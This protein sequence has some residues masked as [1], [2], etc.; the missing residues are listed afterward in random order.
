MLGATYHLTAD[1][2]SSPLAWVGPFGL[3]LFSFMVTFSSHWRRWMTLTSIVVLAFA[4]TWFMVQKGFTAITVNGTTAWCLLV[5]TAAGSFLG[6]AL[7]HSLR[8]A[9]RF[10]RYYLVLAAG[11]VIGGLLSSLIIPYVFSRPIE[12]EL[13]SVALLATGIVWL[14]GRRE[15]SVVIIVGLVIVIP[16]L[17]VGMHQAYRESTDNGSMRHTRDLYG[18]IMVKSDNRSVVLSSDTTT[19][20]SQLTMDAAARRR[21]TLY[22]TESSGVGRV[23]ERLHAAQPSRSVGVIG[24]GAGTLAA[25]ARN[26]DTYDFFDI[27]PK[28][29]RVAQDYFSFIVDARTR[30][31]SAFLSASGSSAKVVVLPLG[32][33]SGS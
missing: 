28:S 32:T 6:N 8:P 30:W 26:D 7:L 17:G 9:Q 31:L 13:A 23:M 20:G 11:G 10:E 15:P 29:I 33:K 25:Y 3:Y 1:I 22:F 21:P 19:H 27:D 12:F 16:V 2:G 5:L 18:H 4:M 14:A 24:L